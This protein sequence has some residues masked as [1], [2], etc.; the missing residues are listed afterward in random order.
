MPN[1]IESVYHTVKLPESCIDGISFDCYGLKMADNSM[2][3]LAD[4]G[5]ILVVDTGKPIN[6]GDTVL[7]YH[8]GFLVRRLDFDTFKANNPNFTDIPVS[9]AKVLGKII[10]CI[11]NLE[12]N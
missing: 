8:S 4:Q 9:N 7:I 11:K 12:N 6:N 1:T 10:M 3:G 2:V 5:D